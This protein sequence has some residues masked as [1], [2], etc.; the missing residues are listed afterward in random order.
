[1]LEILAKAIKSH[2]VPAY[3]VIQ[4]P[5]ELNLVHLKSPQMIGIVVD[6]LTSDFY[7]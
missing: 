2:E 5:N 1:M 7:R 3:I 4:L 6:A